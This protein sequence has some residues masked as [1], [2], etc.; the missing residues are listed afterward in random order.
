M[1]F[2]KMKILVFLL[3]VLFAVNIFAYMAD[4]E[5]PSK[6]LDLLKYH[7]VGNMWLRVSNYGFFG[8]GNDITP[9]WPSLEYP[10]GSGIDYLYQGALWFGAKKI[11]RNESG[12]KLYWRHWPPE[13]QND[14]TAIIDSIAPGVDV[15]VVI[16]T[17]T[18]VGF[19]GD[20]SLNEF[21]PA[22]NPL[23]K[24]AL[25]SQY[26]QWALSDTVL[27]ASIRSQ[28]RG[29]DDDGDGLIDEDAPGF[30]FPFRE[31]DELPSVFAPYGGDFLC[32]SEQ[33]NVP[34]VG[35]INAHK[36]IWFPLGFVNLGDKSNEL[37]NFSTPQ[38]DDNDGL[39]DEDGYPV[40][41]QDYI[42]YYYD[43]SPFGTHGQRDWGSSKGSNIHVPLNV[44]VRQMSY[45]W[46]YEYIKNLVYVEF[47]ITNMNKVDTLFDCVMGIYMD[48]DVGPQA[49][50]ATARASD[51]VSSY[52][53]G[54]G[55]EFAYTYDADQDGGLTTG[56]VGSRVCSPD[57]DSLEF[58]CWT[59]KVGDGPD[60][61][62]PLS[63]TASPTANQKYWL[64]TGRNPDNSKYTSLRDFP[65]V[66]VSEPCDT[67]YLFAFYGDQQGAS[68]N[69]TSASWNLQPGKTMKIVIAI[70]PGRSIAELTTQATWSAT[71]YGTPQRLKEVVIPDTMSHYN[72]PEPPAAPSTYIDM[73]DDGNLLKVYWDNRSEF[74]FDELTI[75]DSYIG[76]QNTDPSLDSY[77]PNIQEGDD[78]YNENAIISPDRAFRLRHD[79]QG[80]A[81]YG[82]SGNGSSEYWEMMQKWDKIDSNQDLIDYST[83]TQTDSLGNEIYN[84]GGYLGIDRGF[85]QKA[86]ATEADTAYYH[87]ND[88]YQLVHYQVGDNIYGKP[89]Y[90]AEVDYSEDF[91]NSIK[92]LP[93]EAQALQFKNPEI[94][95]EIFLA[96]YQDKLIPIPG[97]NGQNA[98]NT[99][100]QLLACRQLRLASRYYNSEIHNPPKGIEYYVSVVAWDRGLPDKNILFLESGKD[101]NMKVLFPGPSAKTNMD[102]IYVVPNPYRGLSK[103]DGRRA[104]DPNGDKSKRIWFVN[105][106]K[107]CT[108]KIFTLAG[109][110]V[111]EIQHNGATNQ[112]IITVS[113]AAKQ[114]LQADGIE[115]WD[116]LSKH[117][118]IIASGLY[119]FSVKDDATGDKKVGKF[120]IIK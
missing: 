39:I 36:S 74:A 119:L 78:N 4:K 46:S 63:T 55:K 13:D 58:A 75:E 69:P 64:L 53:K 21:L 92:D 35:P 37:Y 113:K 107:K 6:K 42:S 17:L 41:E 67:R 71:V 116:L 38:D 56:F 18:T 48:S 84:Y 79:F 62:N 52:V 30:S 60:D 118:Q 106:P 26:S 103:F 87:F 12:D 10:G 50:G 109:D 22:Y 80:Y 5:A 73:L 59:W 114:G 105:L 90:N 97:H 82:R 72:P 102:N 43:Y 49:Y 27:S 83:C 77:D 34:G 76:Y 66:Q 108:I 91:Y 31:S 20:A 15:R 51:D 99:P 110:L 32:N 65:N 24:S 95:D 94:S 85:P 16:D 45:Q 100:E 1:K 28:R 9:Q 14:V 25:G 33:G 44:R 96:L 2:S 47:D 93:F 111:D 3:L 104:N 115:P 81:L 86:V 98:I 8:S 88:Q 40:S 101:A 54:E 120:V 70:F 19:D 112:D 89:L 117:N 29:E 7:N 68:S 61:F 57:P 23:E 11:R